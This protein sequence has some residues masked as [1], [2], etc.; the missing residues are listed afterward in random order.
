MGNQ[1][2]GVAWFGDFRVS[3]A[4]AV[5]ETRYGSEL[6]FLHG[7]AETIGSSPTSFVEERLVGSL[8]FLGFALGADI[9]NGNF[10]GEDVD[11]H[12]GVDFNDRKL[13]LTT[14]TKPHGVQRALDKL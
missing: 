3:L 2:A 1:L 5:Q 7:A 12:C 6:P 13:L 8:E 11:D 9:F 14:Q 4:K 10:Q